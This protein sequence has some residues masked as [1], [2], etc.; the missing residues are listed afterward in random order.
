MKI[1]IT[2]E[3]YKRLKSKI[4][5]SSFSEKYRNDVKVSTSYPN[6]VLYKGF[7]IDSIL[8]PNI[9]VVFDIDMYYKQWGINGI[10][11]TGI[12]GESE[13]E[14]EVNFYD[15]GIENDY[16]TETITLKLNWEN[17]EKETQDGTGIITVDEIELRLA[18]D[19]NGGLIVMGILANVN[20][21]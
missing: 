19:A 5:E 21:I 9:S 13:I 2:E 18:N 12:N 20:M 10:D 8:T 11:V 6:K 17:V 14:V 16:S 1:K 15:N 3:Q 4:N 7:E